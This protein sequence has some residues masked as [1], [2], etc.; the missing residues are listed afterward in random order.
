MVFNATYNNILVR[1]GQFYY[2]CAL[3]I[4]R[5]WSF[6][7]KLTSGKSFRSESVIY[8]KSGNFKLSSFGENS[9]NIAANQRLGLPSWI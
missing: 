7:K 2:Y 4:V 1:D 5:R 6:K 3:V 8:D 9:P